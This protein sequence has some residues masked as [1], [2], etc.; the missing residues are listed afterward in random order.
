[1][2]NEWWYYYVEKYSSKLEKYNKTYKCNNSETKYINMFIT[3]LHWYLL[4]K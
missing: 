1:M 2:I 4:T 3:F